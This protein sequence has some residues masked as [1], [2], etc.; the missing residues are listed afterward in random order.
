MSDTKDLLSLIDAKDK[1]ASKKKSDQ[2]LEDINPN[3]RVTKSRSKVKRTPIDPKTC[4]VAA[5]EVISLIKGEDEHMGFRATPDQVCFQKLAKDLAKK[6]QYFRGE[7]FEATKR[8]GYRGVEIR[9]SIW[10]RWIDSQKHFMAWFFDDFP[11]AQEVSESELKMMDIRFWHGIRNAMEGGEE[12]A[13]RQYA[14]VRFEK[15]GA[16]KSQ[17]NPAE[18]DELRKYFKSGGG[19]RWRSHANGA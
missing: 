10:I 12:W 2:K 15:T 1:K 5:P 4:H 14:R 8:P 16:K 3:Y 19:E 9:E 7:W 18:L 13:Y 6:G 11:L 17:E